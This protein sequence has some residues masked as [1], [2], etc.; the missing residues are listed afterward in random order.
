MAKEKACC[1]CCASYLE[2]VATPAACKC[3]R[4]C[5]CFEII[6]GCPL[7]S[8]F[9]STDVGFRQIPQREVVVGE[10]RPFL[11]M[12]CELS[13]CYLSFPGCCQAYQKTD[14]LCIELESLCCKPL[15]CNETKSHKS[16]LCVFQK[17][18]FYLVSPST[19]CKSIVQLFCLDNRCAFPCDEDVPCLFLPLP[20][21]SL[22]ANW[23][24]H[25]DCCAK[26]K[27]MIANKA[28]NA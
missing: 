28:N 17:A 6:C 3:Y 22:F 14:C 24:M 16:S 7:Q 25:I 23:N 27:D 19:C 12:C 8:G 20:F 5:F 9:L 4:Q 1:I 2:C 18:H 11:G 10:T 21:C 15:C 26:V 13:T